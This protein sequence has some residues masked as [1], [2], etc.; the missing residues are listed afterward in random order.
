MA[1]R[2]GRR[3]RARV[4]ALRPRVTISPFWRPN[5]PRR[6]H[7]LRPPHHGALLDAKT[8]G[9]AGLAA[10]DWGEEAVDVGLFESAVHRV[11]EP[12]IA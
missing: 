10:D 11:D 7:H 6:A 8:G 4:G 9:G 5:A 2:R 1:G 12:S 3:C